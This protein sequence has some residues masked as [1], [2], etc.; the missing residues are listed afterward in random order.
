[1]CRGFQVKK[2]FVKNPRAHSPYGFRPITGMKPVLFQVDCN[3]DLTLSRPYST[4]EGFNDIQRLAC[5]LWRGKGLIQKSG[6]QVPLACQPNVL[7]TM[8]PRYAN[9]EPVN[10]TFGLYYN[11]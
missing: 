10:S 8:L 2:I 7:T 3:P 9:F 6:C 11:Q 5:M 4:M 1:M